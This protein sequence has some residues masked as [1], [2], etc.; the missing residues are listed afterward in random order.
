MIHSGGCAF[1]ECVGPLGFKIVE[2]LPFRGERIDVIRV[3]LLKSIKTTITIRTTIWE[4]VEGTLLFSMDIKLALF[5]IR[6]TSV[7]QKTTGLPGC[8]YPGFPFYDNHDLHSGHSCTRL[9]C[10]DF[11]RRRQSVRLL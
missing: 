6:A 11:A 1:S 10:P 4:M 3:N 2:D 7:V 8:K 5:D 9:F